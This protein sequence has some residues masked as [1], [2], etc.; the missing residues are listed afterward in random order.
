MFVCP[1]LTDPNFG[2]LGLLFFFFF[3]F[4]FWYSILLFKQNWNNFSKCIG[5]VPKVNVLAQKVYVLTPYMSPPDWCH[6]YLDTENYMIYI[7]FLQHPDWKKKKKREREKERPTNP[8]NFQAKTK[9]QTNLYFLRSHVTFTIG[10][11]F[12]F[13][14]VFF[15]FS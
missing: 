8:L 7:A 1:F 11:W 10:L 9:G 5:T 15:F 14:F 4:F 2:K 3:F 6:L 13:L 12:V